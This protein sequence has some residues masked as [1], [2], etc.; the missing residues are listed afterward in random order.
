MM[1]RW[2]AKPTP[3]YPTEQPTVCRTVRLP[4][5]SRL[6]R[7]RRRK[8]GR[9]NSKAYRQ[10]LIQLPLNQPPICRTLSNHRLTHTSRLRLPCR[11]SI[12]RS[13]RARHSRLPSCRNVSLNWKCN[14]RCRTTTTNLPMRWS[15]LNAP[16]SLLLNTWAMATVEIISRRNRRRKKRARGMSVTGQK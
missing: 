9:L 4:H 3:N 12:S 10:H 8:P 6:R 2:L 16:I 14:S 11:I 7:I 5:I 13:R 1:K 15:Y